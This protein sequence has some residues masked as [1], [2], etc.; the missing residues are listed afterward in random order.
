MKTRNI[1]LLLI[2]VTLACAGYYFFLR[3]T[4]AAPASATGESRTTNP[5]TVAPVTSAAAV[6]VVGNGLDVGPSS[7]AGNLYLK[8]LIDEYYGSKSYR[9]FFEK[10]VN[11]PS[12]STARF[13]AEVAFQRCAFVGLLGPEKFLAA[14][15]AKLNASSYSNIEKTQYETS[16]NALTSACA[17]FYGS[18][19]QAQLTERQREFAQLNGDEASAEKLANR[20]K[21]KGLTGFKEEVEPMLAR[22][23]PLLISMMG[24]VWEEAI[25]KDSGKFENSIF[26][27]TSPEVADAAWKLAA[28]EYGNECGRKNEV[29]LDGCMNRVACSADS[30]REYYQK[31]AL[32]PDKFDQVM[33]TTG[34]ILDAL[35]QKRLDLLYG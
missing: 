13:L 24:R 16:L 12:S 10:Y 25:R 15:R 18:M 32:S 19:T 31:Y 3:D 23:N 28:C 7:P 26:A 9:S 34:K 22:G 1:L 17:D 30:L 11:L 35:K 27:G 33:T 29:V 14:K 2:A 21:D 4:V 8:T 6:P 5:G 20:I